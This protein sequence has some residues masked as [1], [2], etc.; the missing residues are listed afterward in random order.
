MWYLAA[1][2][3]ALLRQT[4][5][6]FSS[7]F[8]RLRGHPPSGRDIL[9]YLQTR[10]AVHDGVAPVSMAGLPLVLYQMTPGAYPGR[11]AA[12]MGNGVP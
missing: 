4:P 7:A 1:D 11:A 10:A 8:D 12:T 3:D 6:T 2:R 9:A 5:D